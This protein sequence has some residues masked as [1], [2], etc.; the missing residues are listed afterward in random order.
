ML[1]YEGEGKNRQVVR[2]QYKRTDV[3][4]C[5]RTALAGCLEGKKWLRERL[6]IDALPAKVTD[7]VLADMAAQSWIDKSGSHINPRNGK[8]YAPVMRSYWGA[9]ATDARNAR[10]QADIDTAKAAGAVLYTHTMTDKEF[11]SM[12]GRKSAHNSAIY[13]LARSKGVTNPAADWKGTEALYG[14][15]AMALVYPVDGAAPVVESVETVVEAPA[16]QVTT[17]FNTE[18]FN[19]LIAGGIDPIEALRIASL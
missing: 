17:A 5:V 15:A 1:R 2:T 13:H 12:T 19:T 16:T 10:V 6:G 7:E 18:I 3:R 8:P 4:A 11:T 14:E 9:M